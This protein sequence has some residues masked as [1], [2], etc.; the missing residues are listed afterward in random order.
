MM[1]APRR[2]GRRWQVQCRKIR[3]GEGEGSVVLLAVIAAIGSAFL[4][5]SSSANRDCRA[6]TSSSS[7][8]EASSHR[9]HSS[10]GVRPG[11]FGESEDE[12][13]AKG[14]THPHK[15]HLER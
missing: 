14:D 5:S 13:R 12:L 1:T 8:S 9:V 7:C 10:W 2:R 15:T 11:A 6:A 3:G 4:M